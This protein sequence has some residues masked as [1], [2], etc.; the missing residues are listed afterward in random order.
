MDGCKWQE[1]C[2]L[3]HILKWNVHNYKVCSKIFDQLLVPS[4]WPTSRNRDGKGSQFGFEKRLEHKAKTEPKMQNYSVPSHHKIDK[5]CWLFRLGFVNNMQS[6]SKNDT[7]SC[8]SIGAESLFLSL[9]SATWLLVHCWTIYND[10]NVPKWQIKF[11]KVGSKF[12]QMLKWAL[13]NEQFVVKLCQIRWGRY[14]ASS[15]SK[16]NN[17]YKLISLHRL[18]KRCKQVCCSWGPLRDGIC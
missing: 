2:I 12:C 3:Q 16:L 11:T 10:E 6:L 1:F 17:W 9:T 7:M 4:G 15:S 18:L 13:K 5:L 14:D 8:N